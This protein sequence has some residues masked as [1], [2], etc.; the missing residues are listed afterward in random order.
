MCASRCY[1]RKGNSVIVSTCINHINQRKERQRHSTSTCHWTSC[2]PSIPRG[3]S[4]R[5]CRCHKSERLDECVAPSGCPC[6]PKSPG[7]LQVKPWRL[8]GQA[9]HTPLHHPT[10]RIHVFDVTSISRGDVIRHLKVKNAS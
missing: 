9:P 10:A 1:F 4:N 2:H 3:S 6:W 7:G 8:T 5:C